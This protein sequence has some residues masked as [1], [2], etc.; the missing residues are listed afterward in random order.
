MNLYAACLDNR[1]RPIHKWKHY[2]PIYERHCGGWVNKSVTVLEI[3]CGGGGSLQMWKRFFGPHAKII[4]L[5]IRPGCKRF[6]EDQ[7]FVQI[8]AQQDEV[9]LGRVIDEFGPPD[10]VIDDGSHV[11]SH[12]LATFRILYPQVSKNGIYMVEDVETCYWERYEGGLGRAGTFVEISKGLIDELNADVARRKLASPQFA[13][14]TLSMHFY[15]GFIVF[16]RGVPTRPRLLHIPNPTVKT[17]KDAAVPGTGAG[18][19]EPAV[20]E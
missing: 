14:T 17:E 8:G 12:I 4:G 15:P 5:D 10:I 2:F 1:N 20:S 19:I 3:G 16:E 11:M 18:D 9:F 6:E 7:I 13:R